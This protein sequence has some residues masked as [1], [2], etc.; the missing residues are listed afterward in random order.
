LSRIQKFR[1]WGYR[2]AVVVLGGLAPAAVAGEVVVKECK[3]TFVQR[4]THSVDRPGLID[5][6]PEEGDRVAAG[7]LVVRLQDEVP[8]ANLASASAKAESDVS[9]RLEEKNAETA[10]VEYEAAVEANRLASASIPAYP[11]SHVTRL[12]LLLEGA[13]LKVQFEEHERRLNE[14]ARDQAQAEL[15][16]FR[17]HS[18]VQGVVVQVFK[19]AGEGVQ[20]GEAILELVNTDRLRVEGFV[21]VADAMQIKP[22]L[23]V[24]VHF[25]SLAGDEKA[26]FPELEGTLGFVDVSVHTLSNR[27]RVWA[28]IDNRAGRLREGL[29]VTMLIQ[30][31]AAE[32]PAP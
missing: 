12:R 32:G 19:H 25:E 2:L 7:D 11:P 26:V 27:V 22:G 17:I 10:L 8:R 14:L 18:R 29:P 21:S 9:I 23:P 4:I 30:V 24:R 15:N 5:F 28:D 13:Q 3:T 6:V 1:G 31:G 20:Q 16:T